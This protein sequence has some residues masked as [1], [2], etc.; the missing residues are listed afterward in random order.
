[1]LEDLR[2]HDAAPTAEEREWMAANPFRVLLHLVMLA[3]IAL[4]IGVS[5]SQLAQDSHARPAAI[6]TTTP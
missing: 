3:S 6:A 4:A 2:N 5:G 1:M